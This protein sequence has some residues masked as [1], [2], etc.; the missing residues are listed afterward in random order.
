MAAVDPSIVRIL[1]VTSS[2]PENAADPRGIFVHRLA[3][4]LVSDGA[5]VTVVAPGAPAAPIREERDGVRVVRQ[6]YWIDRWQSLTR[7]L[8]GMA[9]NIRHRPWLL[10]QLPPLLAS[11]AWR[12]ALEAKHHDVVHAHWLYP[13]GIAAMWG[14]RLAGKPLVITSHGGDLNLAGSVRVLRAL[15]HFVGDAAAACIGVSEAVTEAFVSIGV[16]PEKAVFIP[17]GVDV[18]STADLARLPRSESLLRF[19]SSKGLRILYLGSLIPRKSVDTLIDAHARL[20][21]AGHQVVTAIVGDG[22]A[23]PQLEEA[24]RRNN[25]SGVIM[26]GSQPPSTVPAWLAGAD[27]LV[28]PSLSEGRPTVVI[29]AMAYGLAVVGTDIPG[30][31]ELV[32]PELTGFLVPP[33]DDDALAQ[34][35]LQ[36]A[37]NPGTRAAMGQEARRKVAGDGLTTEACARRHMELY[38]R[39]L[40][41]D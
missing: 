15:S 25:L 40:R 34:R 12:T 26:A 4:R 35:L 28:L 30:T 21:R 1:F 31:R 13:G 22:P 24:I 16:P 38:K 37:L 19:S 2:Y 17:L 39:V 20:E 7:G 14:A 41:V 10:A 36:L 27:V 32:S 3:R 18:E 5:D 23:A 9:P 29:E 33:R 6:R 11:M 8:A